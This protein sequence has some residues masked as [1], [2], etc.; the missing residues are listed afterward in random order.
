VA[1]DPLDTILARIPHRAPFLYVDAIL[2]EDAEHIET[3]WTPP[4]DADFFRGHYPGNPI[5]PGVLILEMVFQ[6]AALHFAGVALAQGLDR[7]D[8]Q[9]VLTRVGNGR[10]KRMGLPGEPLTA[11][12]E[13][14]EAL[15]PARF[16]KA[17][18]TNAAGQLVC[19]CDFAVAAAARPAE[20]GAEE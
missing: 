12:L 14:T 19:S 20:S 17:R 9:P 11:R 16:M 5:V 6:S 2:S 3:R 15:G 8:T 1:S 4:A 13:L 18:V 10:F 7:G